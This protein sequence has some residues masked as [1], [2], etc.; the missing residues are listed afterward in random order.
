M[1]F[2]FQKY[3]GEPT[4]PSRSGNRSSA[5]ERWLPI[6]M[7]R[8]EIAQYCVEVPDPF[9]RVHGPIRQIVGWTP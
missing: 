7:I 6:S 9:G 1:V 4:G 5:P 3:G 8:L 2:N